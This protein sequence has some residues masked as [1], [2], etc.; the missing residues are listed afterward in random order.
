MNKIS[1]V[2]KEMLIDCINA[3]DKYF[4]QITTTLFI[5]LTLSTMLTINDYN[6][7]IYILYYIL[8]SLLML[9]VRTIRNKINIKQN[10]FPEIK[11]RFTKKLDNEMIVISKEDWPGAILYLYEIENFLGK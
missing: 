10:G 6:R 5:L 9:I 8:F 1:K 7:V 4:N 3:L 2:I 11:K